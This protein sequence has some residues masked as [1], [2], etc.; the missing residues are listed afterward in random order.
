MNIKEVKLYILEHYADEPTVSIA[1][2]LH[3]SADAVRAHAIRMGLKKGHLWTEE[4]DQQLRD[5]YSDKTNL[6]IAKIMGLKESQIVARACALKLKKS[7]E[8]MRKCCMKSAFRKGHVPYNKGMKQEDYMSEE[9]IKRTMKTRFQKGIIPHNT[10]PVGS[11]RINKD[12]YVMVK[13]SKGMF[14]PKHIV[15]WEEAYGKVPKGHM[16]IFKDGDRRN[17][18]IENLEM[19]SFEENM[20]RNSMYRYPEEIQ[21]VLRTIGVLNRKI[22]K[23]DKENGKLRD[24]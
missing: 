9:T 23:I 22:N 4:R 16:V 7:K 10:K 24:R 19:I 14:R 8:F 2:K 20:K 12:G 18:K 11:E 13:S 15:L 3:C 17:I 1:K 21:K 6:E 5:I